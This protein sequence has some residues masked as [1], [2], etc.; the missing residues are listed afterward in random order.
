MFFLYFN[1]LEIDQNIVWI[2]HDKPIQKF[3]RNIIHEMLKDG[4]YISK[5]KKH[6]IILKMTIPCW[7]CNFSFV[8]FFNAYEIITVICKSILV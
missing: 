1:T 5:F 2:V 7:E 8:S 4:W 6:D 3:A